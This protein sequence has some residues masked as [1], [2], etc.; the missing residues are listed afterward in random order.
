MLK[1]VIRAKDIRAEFGVS[2]STAY[3]IIREIKAVSDV[4]GI[5]GMVHQKDYQAYINRFNKEVANG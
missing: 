3:K 5:S 4:L 2:L 1:E